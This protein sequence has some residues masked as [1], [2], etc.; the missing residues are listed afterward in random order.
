MLPECRVRKA[1]KAADPSEDAGENQLALG[2]D[3]VRLRDVM[4]RRTLPAMGA[5]WLA[6][7]GMWKPTPSSRSR[8]S[9]KPCSR[10][11][12]EGRE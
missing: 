1:T 8:R 3:D 9:N 2:L 7:C 6:S 4:A 12:I 5:I 10:S 11:E